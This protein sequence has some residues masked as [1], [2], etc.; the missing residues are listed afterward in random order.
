MCEM[1]PRSHNINSIYDKCDK[2]KQQNAPNFVG[3]KWK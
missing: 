1:Q 3:V 2:K